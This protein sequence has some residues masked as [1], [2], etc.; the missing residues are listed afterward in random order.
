MKWIRRVIALTKR[1]EIWDFYTLS[2]DSGLDNRRKGIS[3]ISEIRGC[4]LLMQSEDDFLVV[5]DKRSMIKVEIQ[6]VSPSRFLYEIYNG[7]KG[8]RSRF[9]A[10][11]E[12]ELIGDFDIVKI[13]R[14]AYKFY[15]DNVRD[16]DNE[17]RDAVLSIA[18]MADGE[19]FEMS[20]LELR[21]LSKR[22]FR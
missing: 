13:S 2:S 7:H 17:L 15:L 16:L 1:Y 19:E 11:L 22:L 20:E 14:W 9:C 5:V 8:L 18:G 6:V 10:N 12:K 4:L 3:N 21:E